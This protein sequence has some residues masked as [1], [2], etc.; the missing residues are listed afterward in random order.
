MRQR[1]VLMESTGPTGHCPHLVESVPCEDPM[2]YRWL[3]SEGI[4]IPDHGKCGPGHRILKAVC[5]NDRGE[6]HTNTSMFEV[7]SAQQWNSSSL[8]QVIFPE[9]EKQP[10]LILNM[11]NA[12]ATLLQSKLP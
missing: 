7:M 10:F 5:Q 8:H 9:G 2:C 12:R 6:T 11:F 1:H 3:A 4:C